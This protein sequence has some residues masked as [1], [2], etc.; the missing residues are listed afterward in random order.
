MAETPDARAF[1]IVSA[2]LGTS[3]AEFREIARAAASTDTLNGFLRD[4]QAR[5]P[6]SSPIAQPAPSAA[7]AGLRRHQGPVFICSLFET[8]A[9]LVMHENCQQDD[10]RQRNS[11]QPKQQSASKTHDVLLNCCQI[12]NAEEFK[13]VPIGIT[14]K[15]DRR[16]RAEKHSSPPRPLYVP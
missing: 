5:Y 11:D 15:S 7:P 2:P 13:V 6:E 8:F 1:E 12:D 3:G 14:S 10:N 9:A 16:N 4:M